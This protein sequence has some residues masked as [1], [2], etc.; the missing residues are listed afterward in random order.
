MENDLLQSD[1]QEIG[2]F[3][4]SLDDQDLMELSKTPAGSRGIASNTFASKRLSNIKKTK[5]ASRVSAA[6]SAERVKTVSRP[7]SLTRPVS[8]AETALMSRQPTPVAKTLVFEEEAMLTGDPETDKRTVMNLPDEDLLSVIV[9]DD[10]VKNLFE[11]DPELQEFVAD[12]IATKAR[13]TLRNR[14]PSPSR[15]RSVSPVKSRTVERMSELS[16]RE[17]AASPPASPTKRSPSPER[18]H[19]MSASKTRA[20]AQDVEAMYA[21]KDGGFI[22]CVWSGIDASPKSPRRAQPLMSSTKSVTW[23]DRNASRSLSR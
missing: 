4:N 8:R 3:A 12:R 14:S 11:N 5:E 9:N 19:R 16:L 10:Y 6:R 1:P 22:S 15:V 20:P 2:E 21:E 18:D 17:K 13:S 7:A 23:K